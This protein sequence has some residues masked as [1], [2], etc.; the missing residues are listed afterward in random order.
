MKRILFVRVFDTLYHII[1]IYQV[2]KEQIAQRKIG[3]FPDSFI[4]SHPRSSLN[5]SASPSP[6][7]SDAFQPK[8]VL[9]ASFSL[10]N[11]ATWPDF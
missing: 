2:A 5:T 6:F 7:P 4:S 1:I 8:L 9:E 11:H 3:T 10:R